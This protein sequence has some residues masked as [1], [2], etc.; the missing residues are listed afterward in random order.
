MPRTETLTFGRNR[1]PQIEYVFRMKEGLLQVG[2][3]Q[4]LFL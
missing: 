2:L 1:V 3:Q 4:A